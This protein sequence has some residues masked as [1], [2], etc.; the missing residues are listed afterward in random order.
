MKIGFYAAALGAFEQEKRMD[1]IAN[2]LANAATPGYKRDSVHFKDFMFQSTYPRLDQG[3]IA[4][5]GNPLDIALSGAGYLRVQS[6]EGILYT[7]A[8]NLKLSRDNVLVTQE[9]WPVLGKSGPITVE[10]ADFRIEPNGQIFDED[11]EVATLDIVEF[12]PD[13]RLEKARNGYFKPVQAA[14]APIP[15]EQCIVQQGALEGPNFDMVQEMTQLIE[16]TRLFEAYQKTLRMH[17]EQDANITSKLGN[18]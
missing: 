2:N 6:D 18:P 13:A 1:V 9:G 7:R 12:P 17:E 10:K 3:K 5:T 4:Q 16:T 14:T 11:T 15:A 8:G